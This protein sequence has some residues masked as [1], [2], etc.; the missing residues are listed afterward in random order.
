MSFFKGLKYI[1]NPDYRFFVNSVRGKYDGISDKEYIEKK[2]CVC[3]GKNMDFTTPVSFNEKLQWLKLY[4]RRTEY[5]VMVDKYRVREYISDKIGSEYLV[6]LLGVWDEPNE[7]NFEALPER[8]VLKCNHNSGLGMYICHDKKRLN[9][10]KVKKDLIKGLKQNYYLTGREWPYKDVPRLII[11]EQFLQSDEGGL[12]DYKVHCFNGEP[13]LILVC[14]DRF[15][16][17]GLTE[18]FYSEKWEHLNIRRPSH[19]NANKPI[20][21]PDELKKILELS[22]KLSAGIPFLRVDFYIIEHKIY[23][24]ELTFFPA[25]GFEK[26]EPEEWDYTLGSWL[27]LPQNHKA[28]NY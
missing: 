4:D 5:T 3:F 11:A 21:K 8:F 28:E 13:K 9:I 26:F 17:T 14:K 10:L 22:K 7:I 1:L 16:S 27:I 25:S 20:Q 24:S 23:F 6:P 2:Y 18:D 15:T 19:P 12:T